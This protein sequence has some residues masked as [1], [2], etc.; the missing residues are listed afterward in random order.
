VSSKACSIILN[1]DHFTIESAGKEEAIPYSKI[2]VVKLSR[3]NH[4]HYKMT[5]KTENVRAIKITNNYYLPT[6]ECEDRSRQY[7]NFVKVFHDHMKEK[8][9]TVFLSSYEKGT[10]FLSVLFAAFTS[11]LISFISEFYKFKTLHPLVQAMLFMV[12]T[13]ALLY[14]KNRKNSS[15]YKP[16]KIPMQFL[17]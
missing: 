4:P 3:T 8:K 5:L 7:T 10:M 14:F 16:D 12:A 1:K 2:N 15:S 13:A 9:N 11:V 6:G 17:P